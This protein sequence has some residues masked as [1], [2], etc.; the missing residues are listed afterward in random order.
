MSLYTLVWLSEKSKENIVRSEISKIDFLDPVIYVYSRNEAE[1]AI[2]KFGVELVV[3]DRSVSLNELSEEIV[4][5]RPG[6]AVLVLGPENNLMG[7]VFEGNQF[8]ERLSA[9]ASIAH[10]GGIS[11]AFTVEGA[12]RIVAGATKLSEMIQESVFVKSDSV[13]YRID[14]TD[15]VCAEAQKDYVQLHTEEKSYR[16][17]SSMKHVE[18]RLSDSAFMRVH[19]SYIVRI[20]AIDSIDGDMITARGYKI[21]IGP[22]YRQALLKSLNFM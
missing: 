8:P 21:P 6:T 5:S 18:A 20:D 19:R 4:F 13:I 3:I 16:I 12:E 14:L 2:R 17:L 9:L 15:L 11:P 22:S 1:D 10:H 7:E